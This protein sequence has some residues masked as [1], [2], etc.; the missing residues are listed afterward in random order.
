MSAAPAAPAAPP[1]TPLEPVTPG[2][3][4]VSSPGHG[5][6]AIRRNLALDVPVAVGIGLTTAVVGALVPSIARQ[7][8]L[9][10]MGIAVLAAA[11]FL[12]NLL[13][14]FAG[15]FG[16]QGIPGYAALR[17]LGALLLVAIAV[18]PGALPILGAAGLFWLSVSFGA[19]FQTRL[20][21]AM[22]P[23][24]IRGRVI[25]VLG[26]ARAAAAGIA[27]LA[28]GFGA[29]RLGVPLAISLAGAAGAVCALAALG[30]GSGRPLP[31]RQ[32]SAREAVAALAASPRLR[33]YVLAQ[34]LYGAGMIGASPLYAMVNVDR[35]H[36][37]LTDV[38][39][40]A[41]L[42]GLATTLS[43]VGWGA[44]VDRRGHVLGLR[45]GAALGVA[46]LLCIALAPDVRLLWISS[47]LAGLSGAA[48]DL[49]IQGAIGA[50][51]S[52]T[53]RA[54]TMAGWNAVTGARGVLAP[55]VVSSAVQVGLVDVTG[56][57]L[58]CLL[59]AS[60]GLALYLDLRIPAG[61]LGPSRLTDLAGR[62]V[63]PATEAAR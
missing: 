53:D 31:A 9:A 45:A 57:L 13:G 41:V 26:T 62:R 48:M 61:L 25:G 46:S 59:P 15:R 55:M 50:H 44:A 33:R 28:V 3:L 24:R 7:A 10:P 43:Y 30:L 63:P 40:L 42:G 4:P 8:G 47:I 23:A 5:P 20:W 12:G 19:P 32:Y 52:L 51:S 14:A 58:L 22:Y 2:N 39:T 49:G 11:P 18:A 1:V 17:V 60:A 16:P 34:A 35:L 29:D 38:G 36:L 37:S 27:A 54:A 6:R 56:A 21:G